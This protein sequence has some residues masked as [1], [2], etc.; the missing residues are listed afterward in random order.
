MRQKE[1]LAE[2]IVPHDDR[3]EQPIGPDRQE[4]DQVVEAEHRK[5]TPMVPARRKVDARYKRPALDEDC[6]SSRRR[7]AT[8]VMLS[9][10]LSGLLWSLFTLS[11]CSSLPKLRGL[12]SEWSSKGSVEH[13]WA[14]YSPYFDAGD[15]KYTPRDCAISQVNIVRPS[16]LH[17]FLR[18]FNQELLQLQRHGARYPTSSAGKK[19]QAAI[20]KLQS[21][22]FSSDPRLAFLQNYTYDLGTDVLVPLGA[23]QL[24]LSQL[25][26]FCLSLEKPS[27]SY[28]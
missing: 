11:T 25:Y 7:L 16:H 23:L 5:E 1:P 27:G 20:E 14:Q 28:A 4:F 22:N 12:T 18:H 13:H 9:L 6:L 15:Y 8:C 3:E 24:V 2:N 26:C 19:Y 10:A 21:A 17:P